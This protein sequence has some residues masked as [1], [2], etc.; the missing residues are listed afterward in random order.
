[1]AFS[2][3]TCSQL[4]AATKGFPYTSPNIALDVDVA[5]GR[6]IRQPRTQ[7]RK[8]YTSVQHPTKQQQQPNAKKNIA[9][10]G[11]A[12]HRNMKTPSF[13][14]AYGHLEAQHV[15]CSKMFGLSRSTPVD[16]VRVLNVNSSCYKTKYLFYSR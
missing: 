13:V 7:R 14:L 6:D 15:M 10:L 4:V 1:M 16:F 5:G 11:A 12:C 8:G 2:A 9:A 3:A